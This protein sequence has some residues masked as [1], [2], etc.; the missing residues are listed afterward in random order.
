MKVILNGLAALKPKTG[1]GHHVANLGTALQSH[2]PQ[3]SFTLYPGKSVSDSIRRINRP[4]TPGTGNASSGWRNQLRALTK[5]A[6]KTASQLHF[7]AF[8]STFGFDL[9]HEPNFVPFATDLPTIVT[10]HDLS[11]LRFPQWHPVDRVRMHE[12]YFRTA[13]IKAAH[14]I[15]VSDAIR[16]EVMREFHIPSDR[17]TT[18]YNGIHPSFQLPNPEMIAKTR[19]K[20]GLPEQ[21]FLCVGTI[22]PRKNL[23]AVMQ[24]FTQ[25]PAETREACPLLLA[26][27]WGWKSDAERRFYD[28]I[29]R[30]NGIRQL[31]YVPETDLPAIY[32]A[33]TALLYPSHYEGFGLPPVEML[34]TGGT[35]IASTD[36]A[37]QEVCGKF[38]VFVPPTDADGWRAAMFRIATDKEYRDAVKIGGQEHARQFTWERAA[39]ETMAVYRRVLTSTQSRP[40]TN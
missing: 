12:R 29:G 4:S 31:G 1:V 35:V 8:T 21:F 32:G 5:S 10:V 25:L 19:A 15:V 13:L 26:G 28:D 34:A 33:A 40:A 16:A 37:V 2:Y 17:V 18:V 3:D 20:F 9:Y 38:A 23:F 14:V 30:H 7:R 22:E 27:P 11:V 24:A 39:D 6:A 36:A